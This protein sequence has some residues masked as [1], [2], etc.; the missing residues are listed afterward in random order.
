MA[1]EH[2]QI[3][4]VDDSRMNRMKLSLSLEQQGHNV[5]LAE[6]GRQALEM[7]R[8]RLFDAVLLDIAMPGMDG[9]KVLERIKSSPELR[10]IPVIVISALDEIEGVVRCIEMGAEDYL[11]KSPNPVLLRARLNASLQ[12]KKLRD[13][14]KA[15]SEQEV[16]LRQSE[17]LATLGRL[18]AGMAHELNNPAA[19]ALRDAAELHTRFSQL[20]QLHLKLN[21]LDLAQ[22]FHEMLLAL[23]GLAQERAKRSAQMDPLTRSDREAEA[24]T[25][26]GEQGVENAWELAPA[27]VSLGLD[28]GELAALQARFGP[29]HFPVVLDW[30]NCIFDIYS[31]LREISQGTGRIAGIVTALKAYTHMDP[32][33]VEAVDVNASLEST[34]IVL[35]GKLLPRVTLCRDYAKDLPPVEAHGSELNQVW[36]NLIDNALEAMNGSGE[37]TIRTHHN[38]QGVVVEIEDNGPGIPEAVLPHIFDPFVTTKPPGQGAGLGLMIC[39]NIVVQKHRGRIDVHSRPGETRFEVSLPLHLATGE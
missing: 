35:C 26:L 20:Q 29:P 32:A 15:Y 38:G 12:R 2:G 37:L 36:T 18:S 17:K 39:H 22:R 24:E 6:N 8:A 31:L 7:L 13:L 23:D 4:V 25:W 19:A 9:Y 11:P 30:L 27:L 1:D 14:E 28:T 21:G 34:L 10:D 33:P 16:V 3:L 5:D